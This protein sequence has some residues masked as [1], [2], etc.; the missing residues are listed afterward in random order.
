[1]TIAE[2]V[3]EK[4]HLTEGQKHQFTILIPSWNN[5]VYLQLCIKSIRKNSSF[6]HQII[7]HINEGIDGTLEWV[8]QQADIDYTY[9][10]KNIG[11]CYALNI[12]SSL[13]HTDYILFMNDDMYVCPDWDSIL[14]KEIQ[15]IGHNYFFLSS[16]MIEPYEGNNPCII[17]KNYGI[18]IE[19]FNEDLLLSEVHS[20][21]KDDWSGATWPPN[22]VH[23]DIWNA[24]GGYSVE[25]HPG[26]YSDPDF[27]MKLWHMGIRV[28]KGLGKS[29]VYHFSRV[30]TGRTKMNKG[31]HTFIQKWGFTPGYFM[32]HIL[33]RGKKNVGLLPQPIHSPSKNLKNLI[34]R[35]IASFKY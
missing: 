8:K 13:S 11:V 22:I 16:T 31:Y 4:H 18:N 24:V 9:S 32:E 23:K 26:L 28:F 33:Q 19:N 14:M 21:T 1:M 30:S 17:H 7:V 20:L 10:N 6:S 15:A 27:S 29:K 34:K 35:V 2:I 25:F 3:I 5:L 12:A